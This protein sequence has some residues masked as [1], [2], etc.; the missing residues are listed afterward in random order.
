MVSDDF[1]GVDDSVLV[2]VRPLSAELRHSHSFFKSNK[3]VFC[4][5]VQPA[6]PAS[7]EVSLENA[8]LNFQRRPDR[9]KRDGEGG[10][11]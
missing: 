10:G 1:E 11:S 5:K 6:I 2:G 8:P 9:I 7:I 3:H 4:D